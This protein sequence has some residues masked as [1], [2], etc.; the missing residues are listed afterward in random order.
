[1]P[2]YILLFVSYY[3]MYFNYLTN[4]YTLTEYTLTGIQL[5]QHKLAEFI[6]C[7]CFDVKNLVAFLT[8]KF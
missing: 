2:M 4:V 7:N 3:L 8:E 1:M 5:R 6:K